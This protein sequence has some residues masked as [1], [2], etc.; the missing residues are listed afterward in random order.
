MTFAVGFLLIL[1]AVYGYAMPR[2]VD[3][4]YYT[5]GNLLFALL[6]II[7]AYFVGASWQD[8][9]L[10]YRPFI[11]LEASLVVLAAYSLARQLAT[12]RRLKLGPKDYQEL[13]IR[14]PFGTALAEELI[15]R[16]AVFGLLAQ[17]LNNLPALLVSSAAFGFW[18]I[19]PGSKS[20]WASQKLIPKKWS[21]WASKTTSAVSTVGFTFLGGLFFGWL[22][23]LSAGII[24][25]WAVHTFTNT[26][27]WT[28]N[29][30]E[31]HKWPRRK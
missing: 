19:L 10:H 26:V 9:G 23:I 20:V 16:G 13:F 29:K 24:L 15:F 18:H 30:D 27:G 17:S 7:Y 31:G 8:L 3:K 11:I 22:R 14:V 6:S 1:I 4:R 5:I 25:P 21:P 28:L 12:K 2:F